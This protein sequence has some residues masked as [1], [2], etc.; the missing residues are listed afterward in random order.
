MFLFHLWL[1]LGFIETVFFLFCCV[2]QDE[3]M[4]TDQS[5]T[6]LSSIQSEIAKYQLLI[7]EENQKLKRYKVAV[8]TVLRHTLSPV[9]VFYPLRFLYISSIPSWIHRFYYFLTDWKHSTK[10]QLP[11]FHHGA[12]EDAG[13]VSAA[14]TFGGKGHFLFSFSLCFFF[15]FQHWV[16]LQH[17][18]FFQ[19]TSFRKD[20]NIFTELKHGWLFLFDNHAHC[21]LMISWLASIFIYLFFSH[22]WGQTMKDW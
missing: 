1:H 5:S 12:T 9:N 8:W 20:W 3:P 15:F 19:S 13:R 6:F 4:D 14:N 7:E 21:F 16:F 10:A 22:I 17:S 2:G 11:S 18:F